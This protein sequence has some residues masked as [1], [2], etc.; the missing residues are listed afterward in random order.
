[1]HR[2]FGITNH[3]VSQRWETV[4][5]NAMNPSARTNVGLNKSVR[6]SVNELLKLK[7]ENKAQPYSA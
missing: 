5:I 7:T 2:R 4:G 6:H 1:M 3:D